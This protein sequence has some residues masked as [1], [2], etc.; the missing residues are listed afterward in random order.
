MCSNEINL[1]LVSPDKRHKAIIYQRDCG[2]TTGF[3][4]QISII[5]NNEKLANESGNVL[6]SDGRPN[7]NDY[8]LKWLRADE[9][10]ISSTHGKR[11]NFKEKSIGVISISY[12]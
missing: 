12:E 1:D 10:L 9:L 8:R 6:T 2:A 3:S 11:I 4:T 5:K 7:D